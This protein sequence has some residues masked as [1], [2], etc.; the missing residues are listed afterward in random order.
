M[1]PLGLEGGD[2]SASRVVGSVRV[3]VGG[4]SPSGAVQREKGR[5]EERICYF[6]KVEGVHV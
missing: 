2:H 3:R 1:M 5:K 4:G 6:S